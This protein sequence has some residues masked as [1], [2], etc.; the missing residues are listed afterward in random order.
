M[1]NFKRISKDIFLPSYDECTIF[2]L[3]FLFVALLVI[4]QNCRSEIYSFYT[5]HTRYSDD[6]RMFI[7]ALIIALM[8]TV[9]LIVSIY[10]VLVKREKDIMSETFMKFSAMLITGMSGIVSGIYILDHESTWIV[11]SPTWN[12]LMGLILLYQIGFIDNINMDQR[13][14]SFAQIFFGIIAV[15]ILLFLFHNIYQLYWAISLSI[16]V[17][18]IIN[19]NHFIVKNASIIKSRAVLISKVS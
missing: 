17:N 12:I 3:N 8:Y 18:F 9:G 1:N 7:F 13:D 19:I 6:T 5:Q 10:H 16:C 14:A 15:S 11:T 4:D 2:L